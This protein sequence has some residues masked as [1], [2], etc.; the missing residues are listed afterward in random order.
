M[1]PTLLALILPIGLASSILGSVRVLLY[2]FHGAAEPIAGADARG[3]RCAAVENI[4]LRHRDLLYGALENLLVTLPLG[5]QLS[6][7]P[8]PSV[9]IPF[10]SSLGIVVTRGVSGQERAKVG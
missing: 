4:A 8:F 1:I 3:S 2:G 10:P 9:F 6:R 7:T 5:N